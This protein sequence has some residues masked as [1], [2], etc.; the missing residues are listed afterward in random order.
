MLHKANVLDKSKAPGKP[1]GKKKT[2]FSTAYLETKYSNM[3][4][5]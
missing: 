3:F 5:L 4:A 2:K 1:M